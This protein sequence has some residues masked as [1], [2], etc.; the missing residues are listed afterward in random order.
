MKIG[1]LERAKSHVGMVVFFW[2]FLSSVVAGGWTLYDRFSTD[3]ELMDHNMNP[4]AHPGLIKDMTDRVSALELGYRK[5]EGGYEPIYDD[6]AFVAERYVRLI[7]SDEETDRQKKA[8]AGDRAVMR[9]RAYLHEHKGT[10]IQTA[11][12]EALER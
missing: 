10:S 12:N 5:V 6:I 4:L 7:A 9:F 8:R 11:V 3:V 2:G 1:L